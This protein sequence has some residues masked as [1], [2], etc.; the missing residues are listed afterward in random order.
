[1]SAFSFNAPYCWKCTQYR[2]MS[3]WNYVFRNVYKF[4]QN[5]LKNVLNKSHKKMH[6]F[7]LCTIIM[8]NFLFIYNYLISVPHTIICKVPQSTTKTREV[9]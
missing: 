2:I 4:I 5:V 8:L 6:G 9:F 1:M 3:K 7:T